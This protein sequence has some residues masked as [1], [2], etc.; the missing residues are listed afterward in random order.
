M[1]KTESIK[2]YSDKLLNIASQVRLL[3]SS[4]LESRIVQKIL[5]TIP[6]KF[7]A[8]ITSLEN[9]KD[10]SKITLSEM[11]N[12]L[13]AQEQRRAM[14]QEDDV[15]GALFVKHKENR[16][17][18]KKGKSYQGSNGDFKANNRSNTGNKKGSYPPCQHYN[19]KSHPHFKCWKRP[20][21][22]CNKCN[23]MGHE[24]VICKSKNQQHGEEAQI[25]DQKEE[26]QLFVATC[27]S[28]IESS[29]SW[30]IDSGCI[31]HMTHDKDLFRE[32]RSSNMSKVRIGNGEYITMEGKGTVAIST[33]LGTKFISDVLY[34]PEIDQNLFSVE[35]IIEKGYKVVFE[36][37]SCLIKDADGHDIFKVKMKGKSF[38][39][40]PLEEEQTAF[41]IKENITGVW[42][43]RLG[44]YHHKGL[45][46]MKS[47]MMVNDLSALDDHIPN[48]KAC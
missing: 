9:T 16:N 26:D 11:L 10:M 18:K 35:Q 32:L 22:K 20:D 13:Q 21:A 24:A 43:K 29:E 19:R 34:V 5:V 15:E 1:K 45:L 37:K 48:C 38:A 36:D 42:H 44:H 23:Q 7:E 30:L 40:N 39:L 33:C 46:Q 14:R 31:N 27:F 3:G 8:T 4:L 28:G 25:A 17:Y 6:E 12:A 2:E 41:P 47:K